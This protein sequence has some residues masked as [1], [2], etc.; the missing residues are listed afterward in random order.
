VHPWPLICSEHRPAQPKN[1]TA[2]LPIWRIRVTSR[3]PKIGCES[4]LL[5]QLLAPLLRLESLLSA[6]ELTST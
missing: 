1:G 3:L 4:L 2:D 6:Q 5:P